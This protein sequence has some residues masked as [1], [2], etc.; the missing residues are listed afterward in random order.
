M[1]ALVVLVLGI[2]VPQAHIF[3]LFEKTHA[4]EW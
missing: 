4:C 3:G 1:V 2:V